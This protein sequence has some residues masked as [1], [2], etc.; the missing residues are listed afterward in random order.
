[1]EKFGVKSVVR[2]TGINENTLRG[3]ERRYNAI[4][5]ER[6]IE[7]HRCYSSK[8]IERIK[9]LW[10]LV[11]EGH[12]IGK[13]S[14]LPN[15][16]LKKLLR[17]S[18]SPAA[19]ELNATS[20]KTQLFLSE[21][22]NALEN[23]ELESLNQVLQKARF[24]MSSKEII[25]NLI[26]PLLE[27]VGQLVY[28]NRISISQEHLLSSLMRDF[29]GNLNQSLSPYDFVSREKAGSVILTTRE[30]DIHEFGILMSSI[31]CNLYRF[32][33]YYLGPNMPVNE[34][35]EAVTQLKVDYVVLGLMKLP[36]DRDIF[37]A[38]NYLRVLDK[39][40]PRQVTICFGGSQDFDSA[41]LKSERVFVKFKSLSD[42][43]VFLSERV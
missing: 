6:D 29:L 22:I 3:W 38:E 19:S 25:I 24:E 10:S 32:R 27:Q 5:P 15:I 34:L 31:L 35:I 21:I 20:P 30:G 40:L 37:S 26:T 42:I 8:D 36:K 7:G 2:L 14:Q 12:A 41:L 18:L 9:M 16:S 17:K 1:M 43:D 11:K 4:S 28:D 33:T 13:I 23:F 39:N